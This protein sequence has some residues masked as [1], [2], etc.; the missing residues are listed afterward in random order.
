MIW[1]VILL[2]SGIVVGFWLGEPSIFR[3]IARHWPDLYAE[4]LRRSERDA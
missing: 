3:G 2:A 1:K 4:M